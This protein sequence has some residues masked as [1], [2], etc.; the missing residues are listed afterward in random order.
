MAAVNSSLELDQVLGLVLRTILETL[1]PGFA[2]MVLLSDRRHPGFEIA[3][4][5][6]LPAG[7]APRRIFPDRCPCNE[8]IAHGMPIFEPTCPGYGCYA[9]DWHGR[10]HSHLVFPLRARQK[11]VGVLCLFCPSDFEVEATELSLWEDIGTQI[12]WAVEDARLQRQ[13][14]REREVSQALYAVSDHLAASLD[15][16]WVLSQV[17]R[18]AVSAA[19][20]QDGSVFLLPAA[21]VVASRLLRRELPATEADQIIE[22]VVT[23]G[24]A[25]WVMRHKTG[26]IVTDTSQDPR[27]LSFPDEPNPAGSALSVPLMADDRVLGI[28]TLD[29]PETDHFDSRQLFLTL[30]IA[31]QASAAIEKARLHKEVSHLAEVLAQRVEDRTRE[32]KETQVQLI[33]A[34]KLAALGELAAGI[35]HEINNPL[36]IL[37]AY[38]EYL[39]SQAAPG[40][41]ILEFLEPMQVSLE[42]IARLAVQLRDFSRPGGGEWKLVS[43]S[44]VLDTVLRLVSKE[45]LRCQIDMETS[46]APEPLE[47][48]GDARQLEQ[49]FL[50]LILNARDAMPGGGR[51]TLRTFTEG[52][53][54]FVSLTD[55]GTGIDESDLTRIFE[56]YFTTKKDRGTGLGLAICQ[57]IVSQHGGQVT[58]SSEVGRGTTFT[59]QLTAAVP[60]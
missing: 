60:Q 58:V 13:I 56:P 8:A 10:Q 59:V 33:Q 49:V 39:V 31:H 50:N 2:G 32:L 23:Q 41:P 52:D 20:A 46:R 16:D 5:E 43:V 57:R 19:D 3:A 35:A 37:Q 42:N 18:L 6:G 36:H 55:T 38:T 34:E 53:G 40:D 17:L 29:H 14:Q 1:G 26:A 9:A 21:G 22:Q 45:L 11:V 28:L 25:G 15:L 47:V 54:I 44:E 12:G 24:L 30:A 4:Q 7:D 48:M 27:W 51:L